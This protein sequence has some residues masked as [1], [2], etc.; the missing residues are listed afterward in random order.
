M[1]FSFSKLS[2]F[3]LASSA[4]R[5]SWEKDSGARDLSPEPGAFL[6]KLIEGTSSPT[7]GTNFLELA[8]TVSQ[9]FGI[10]LHLSFL[11]STK[12]LGGGLRSKGLKPRSRSIPTK[13]IEGTSSPT[14]GTNFLE[15]A[16]TVSQLFGI[17]N[18]QHCFCYGCNNKE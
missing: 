10:L 3:I 13:T 11:C 7:G 1:L 15:L 16:K 6:Q 9:I 17:Y 18:H 4:A 2:H 14:G 12:Q 5:E 8:N